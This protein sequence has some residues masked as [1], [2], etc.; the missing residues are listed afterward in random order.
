MDTYVTK[1][2]FKEDPSEEIDAWLNEFAGGP[3]SGFH[4]GAVVGYVQGE[5]SVIITIKIW[6]SNPN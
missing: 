1:T 6:D 5:G 3:Q 4:N 2:F